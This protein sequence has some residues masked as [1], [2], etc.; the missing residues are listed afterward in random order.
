ME[1]DVI[2]VGASFAGL[3]VT[4]QLRGKRVLVLDRKPL[5]TGQTSACGT[6]VSTLRAL[7]LEESIIQVH[8][9]LVVH[10]PGRTFT[11][12]M[13]EPFC[14]FDYPKLCQL[15]WA[16]SDADFVQLPATGLESRHV[17]TPQG[18][19][20]GRIIVD[21]SGWRAA[22]G[23]SL[24]PNLVQRDRL[25]FGLETT[26]VYRGAQAGLRYVDLVSAPFAPHASAGGSEAACPRQPAGSAPASAGPL[27][28][29][30]CAR[31]VGPPNP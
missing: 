31:S 23:T 17:L 1:Y 14:T 20:A 3:A 29:R 6:L 13:P 25:N 8:D 30:L 16:Q 18:E 7:G 15:L 27:H 5:G 22:L 10:T 28:S 12:P 21:A 9:R 26:Q 24:R 11:Y 4:A 19:Y 2:V